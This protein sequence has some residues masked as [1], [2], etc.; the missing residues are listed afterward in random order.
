M[1]SAQPPVAD[2]ALPAETIP[3]LWEELSSRYGAL[4][5]IRDEGGAASF[6]ELNL[7][8]A[9][10]ARAL[11]GAGVAKGAR[12]GILMPNGCDYLVALFGALRIGAVAVLISTLARPPELAQMIRG[13]DVDILLSADGYLRNDYVAMIETAFPALRGATA[14][15]RLAV[16]QA[17]FL[18]AIWIWGQRRPAWARDGAEESRRPGVSEAL[19]RAAEAEVGATDPALIIFTSGSSAEPK[20]VTHSQG[21]L[22]RQ[23]MALAALMGGCGPGDRILSVM[24][25]F[26]VGGLCTVMMAAFCSGTAVL[27]PADP[28]MEATIACLREGAATHIMHWPQQL[29]LMKDNPRFREL[30][31]GMRPA[32]AHQYELFGLAT[33]EHTANSLGMTETLGPHSMLPIGP[34]PPDKAGSFG[35]A[36]GGIERIIVDPASGEELPA[37]SYGRLCL[38]GGALMTGMHRKAPREV[39]DERGFYHTD[40]VA[41]IDADGH[42]FFSGRGGDIVKVSGANVSPVEVEGVLRGLPGVKAACVVGLPSTGHDTILAAAIVPEDGARLDPDAL[43]EQLRALLSSYKVPRHYVILRQD[44]LPMTAT[45]KIYKP[46]LKELLLARIA[47]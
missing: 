42:L 45:A 21:N 5:A 38:R 25:F 14:A 37:G 31:G 10:M 1:A 29:D 8:S 30:L 40:D 34:L 35:K 15:P 12:V 27:C 32:Y 28:S 7:R 13:A 18:R 22:V 44:E 6:D 26:W 43:R 47:G 33:A 24:P 3:A 39:F 19:L 11:L 36:V 46:A 16:E 41:M 20:A 2:L 9:M 17:P 4:L 23:G